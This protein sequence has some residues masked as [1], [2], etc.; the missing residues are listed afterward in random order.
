MVTIPSLFR[1]SRQDNISCVLKSLVWLAN[2]PCQNDL[3][4]LSSAL[5]VAE[6]VGGAQFYM[7]CYQLMVGGSGTA[8]PSTV[9][10][11]GA[12]AATD[13]GILIDIY[14]SPTAY[15]SKN[16]IPFLG[17]PCLAS[18]LQSPD[19]RPMAQH[20]QRLQQQHGQRPRH[21]IQPTS[22]RPSQQRC[23]RVGS[24][25]LRRLLL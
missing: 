12:Y 7:S 3:T 1:I 21:G 6:S 22:P 20:P 13:P 16:L 23:P 18:C 24:Q 5:H 2:L 17:C 10:I 14:T 9:Q 4:L 19:R 25:S 15:T 8:E 11:P